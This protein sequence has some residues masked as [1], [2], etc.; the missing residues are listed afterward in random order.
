MLGALVA[1]ATVMVAV[2]VA[3]M[4]VVLVTDEWGMGWWDATRS[5]RGS[6]WAVATVT[7]AV[8]AD[9]SLGAGAVALGGLAAL[10]PGSRGQQQRA[11][12]RTTATTPSTSPCCWPAWA[13]C[14]RTTASSPTW[15]TCTTS[16][17]VGPSGRPGHMRPSE[18][19]R[20][21]AEAPQA[22]PRSGSLLHPRPGSA[23]RPEDLGAAPRPPWALR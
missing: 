12:R 22:G 16:S 1:V 5:C 3:Q 13:S 10:S 11:R 17:Q 23:L 20:P 7:V 14:C 19:A 6:W 9:H 15:I 2:V 4:A 18:A 21:P 8:V